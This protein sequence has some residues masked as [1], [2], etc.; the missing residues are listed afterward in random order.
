MFTFWLCII[1]CHASGATTFFISPADG[2]DQNNG[3]SPG[4]PFRSLAPLQQT[5]GGAL[6]L[7]AGDAL[8]LRGA[9]NASIVLRGLI[10][11]RDAPLRISSYGGL[12]RAILRGGIHVENCYGV[13]VSDLVITGPGWAVAEQPGVALIALD[14]GTHA[15]RAYG[16][17]TVAD[18][19][20]SGFSIGV[21]VGSK[22]S[23]RF[24]A[25]QPRGCLGFD[26]V[27]LRRISAHDNRLAGIETHGCS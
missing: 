21:S 12:G 15:S 17:I 2:S 8:L 3:T 6:R 27:S 5:G 10:S 9:L 18:V 4:S 26:G 11:Q 14:D 20:V 25:S 7:S 19:D 1:F 22:M 13:E 23:G 16:A 24:S